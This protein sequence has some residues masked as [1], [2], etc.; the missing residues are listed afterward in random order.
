MNS[1]NNYINLLNIQQRHSLPSLQPVK[2]QSPSVINSTQ[3]PLNNS[4]TVNI[5]SKAQENL[6]KDAKATG[7]ELVKQQ[8]AK[9][10]E[11]NET[12]QITETDRLDKIISDIQEKIKK[13]QKELRSLNGEKNEQAAAQ[14]K[15]LNAQLITLNASLINLMG[16]KLE[17]LAS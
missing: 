10:L 9:A 3:S 15:L 16:K 4:A 7:Q 1:I 12:T 8:L 6:A 17:A 13:A 11:K 5:S 2:Q 14:R